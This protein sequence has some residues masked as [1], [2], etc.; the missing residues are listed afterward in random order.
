MLLSINCNSPD[1]HQD[2]KHYMPEVL[3]N[4]ININ[5]LY[6]KKLKTYFMSQ[7]AYFVLFLLL[8]RTYELYGMYICICGEKIAK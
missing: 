2:T 7:T 4:E 6:K 1:S 5:K 3:A 8:N